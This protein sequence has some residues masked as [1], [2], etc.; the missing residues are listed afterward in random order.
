MKTC[1][2]IFG[3]RQ[4]SKICERLKRD[5][6]RVPKRRGREHLQGSPG[7]AQFYVINFPCN[8]FVD[9]LWNSERALI[10]SSVGIKDG[11]VSGLTYDLLANG[12]A[13]ISI[14]Q[15]TVTQDRGE[16]LQF[17]QP[18]LVSPG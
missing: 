1:L 17:L 2:E 7:H 15:I 12:T 6:C 18:T 11:K 8:T 3:V 13:D 14:S 5:I 4:C 16:A 10:G 9:Y